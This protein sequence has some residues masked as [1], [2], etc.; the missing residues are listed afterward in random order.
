MGK[1][2]NDKNQ[3]KKYY[4]PYNSVKMAKLK[5][6]NK[7]MSIFLLVVCAIFV[8]S[9]F[10]T[11]FAMNGEFRTLNSQ[12]VANSTGNLY[13]VKNFSENLK[14]L[15]FTLGVKSPT[16]GFNYFNSIMLIVF[17]VQLACLVLM[18]VRFKEKRNNFVKNIS[19]SFGLVAATIVQII[20]MGNI[21]VLLQ[22]TLYDMIT[23][24]E[25]LA[26]S[27][28]SVTVS[29]FSIVVICLLFITSLM[30]IGKSYYEYKV[31]K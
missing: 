3:S 16:L 13:S 9:Q 6:I 28:Y 25:F 18:V 8:V 1:K 31:E 14:N 15:N 22:D 21:K 17:V 2:N 20:L 23:L 5:D 10:T 11:M 12:E 24:G 26:E 7:M 27:P 29:A 19:C 4:K 30:M